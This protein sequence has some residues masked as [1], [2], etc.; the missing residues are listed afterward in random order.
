VTRFCGSFHDGLE[1]N[2]TPAANV[3]RPKLY[4]FHKMIVYGERP[5]E[6]RTMAN[7]CPIQAACLLDYLLYNDGDLLKESWEEV[8]IRGLGRNQW[9]REGRI[10]LNAKFTESRFGERVLGAPVKIP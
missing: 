8:I 6:Q 2:L 7:K 3:L 1:K 5:R 9:M 10:A 4:V